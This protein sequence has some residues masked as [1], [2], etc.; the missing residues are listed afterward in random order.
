M[1]YSQLDRGGCNGSQMCLSICK[2]SS[3]LQRGN[4][5]FAI[6]LAKFFS[7]E[8]TKIMKKV[9]RQYMGDGFLLWPAMVNFN[10]FM[11]CLNNLHP[12]MN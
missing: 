12:S 4:K 9:F 6:E 5:L 7:T 1:K 8:E 3:S 2:F 11:V 10:S